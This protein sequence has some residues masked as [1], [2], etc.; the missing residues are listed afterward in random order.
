MTSVDLVR[1]N[2]ILTGV[3]RRLAPMLIGAIAR[4]A[5]SPTAIVQAQLPL[6]AR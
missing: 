2:G 5:S 3:S 4:Q 1:I 6:V